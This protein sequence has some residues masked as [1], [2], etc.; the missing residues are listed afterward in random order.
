[1]QGP[2]VST[3]RWIADAYRLRTRLP[4]EVNAALILGEQAKRYDTPAYK[5]AEAE[6]YANFNARAATPAWL[7]QY[8]KRTGTRGNDKLYRTMWG[9]NEF[10]ADGTLSDYNGE[11]LLP[12]IAAPTLFLSGRFDEG[13]PEASMDFAKRVRHA[14]VQVI[15][16]ASH[17]IQVEQP[18]RHAAAL[19]AWMAAHDV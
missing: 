16:D 18:L 1:M 8:A 6:F 9:P 5:G 10:V 2:Y 17:S 4:L 3:S 19:R 12:L 14:R 15:E 7:S 13:T 11:H